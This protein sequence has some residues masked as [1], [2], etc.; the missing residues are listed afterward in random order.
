MLIAFDNKQII[1]KRR[2]KT[3]TTIIWLVFV[4]NNADKPSST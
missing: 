4:H 2:S 1:D 3:T